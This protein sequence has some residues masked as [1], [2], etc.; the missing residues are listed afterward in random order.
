MS[1]H[2]FE[3]YHCHTSQTNERTKERMNERTVDGA[4][5]QDKCEWEKGVIYLQDSPVCDDAVEEGGILCIRREEIPLKVFTDLSIEWNASRAFQFRWTGN[6]VDT[7]SITF[8]GSS[9]NFIPPL[10]PLRQIGSRTINR[11]GGG[12]KIN[13]CT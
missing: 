9:Y 1:A 8:L 3:L 12:I 2:N 11:G 6:V 10:P 13:N 4:K 5:V 7:S